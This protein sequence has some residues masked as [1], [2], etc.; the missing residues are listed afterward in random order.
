MNRQE[1]GD[2]CSLL[3]MRP[4][5]VMSEL[6]VAKDTKGGTGAPRTLNER[7]PESTFLP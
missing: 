6:R 4:G 7:A 2:F 5:Q 3:Q 1:I